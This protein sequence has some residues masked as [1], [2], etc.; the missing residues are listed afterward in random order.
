MTAP[1]LLILTAQPAR[2]LVIIAITAR[3]VA[4]RAI[5]ARP[6]QVHAPDLAMAY[7][8]RLTNNLNLWEQTP[9]WR[10]FP[11]TYFLL[12]DF[13]TPFLRFNVQSAAP[14]L[15]FWTSFVYST[16][17]TSNPPRHFF[18]F[19]LPPCIP[20]LQRPIH[21]ATSSLLDF[22]R[23]FLCFNVQSAAQLLS[24]WTSSVHS[25][26]STSNPPFFFFPFGL[27]PCIPLLQR[28]IR[29]AASSLLDFLHVFHYF[30]VQFQSICSTISSIANILIANFPT[31]CV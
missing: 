26:A 21:R 25:T 14:L 29:H 30:N 12:L 10:L 4:I 31:M 3:P 17:S 15:P 16:T 2:T 28:P 20:L 23:A 6:P 5:A 19:G 24:F 11:C 27:P 18:P 7:A 13:C 1:T 8:A 22:L 9:A